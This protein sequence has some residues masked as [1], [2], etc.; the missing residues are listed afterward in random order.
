MSD[1]ALF[2]TNVPVDFQP[3]EIEEV[4]NKYGKIIYCE[5]VVDAQ[6]TFKGRAI[7]FFEDPKSVI[8]AI[9]ERGDQD[10]FKAAPY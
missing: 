6:I 4:F 10:I 8:K 7:L 2:V 3:R 1:T 9:Q 5:P